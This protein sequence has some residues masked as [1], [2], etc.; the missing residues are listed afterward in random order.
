MQKTLSQHAEENLMGKMLE[1]G[2]ELRP[3]YE[4]YDFG[5]LDASSLFW[6]KRLTWF[7][8]YRKRVEDAFTMKVSDDMKI[9]FIE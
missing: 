3:K 5:Q 9:L 7:T 2:D 8:H 6:I 1:K 4:N